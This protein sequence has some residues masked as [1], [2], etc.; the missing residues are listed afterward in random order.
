MIRK[1][2]GTTSATGTIENPL[3]QRC[4]AALP[5]ESTCTLADGVGT[6]ARF[7]RVYGIVSDSTSTAL[8]VYVRARACEK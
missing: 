3:G 6:A 1:G 5:Q 8:Y 7:A 2:T 4:N